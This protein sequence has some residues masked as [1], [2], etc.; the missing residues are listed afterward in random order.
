M[1]RL[2]QR[3]LIA[4]LA[5]V[6]EPAAEAGQAV[7]DGLQHW[8]AL[9]EFMRSDAPIRIEMKPGIERPPDPDSVPWLLETPHT[10][11]W[12]EPN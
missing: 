12:I 7:A 8:F 2:T 1:G 9:E 10:L 5:G 11:M 6:Y 4:P 3:I